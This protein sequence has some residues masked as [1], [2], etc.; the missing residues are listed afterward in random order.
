MSQMA[1]VP[2]LLDDDLL[3]VKPNYIYLLN[4]NLVRAELEKMWYRALVD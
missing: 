4:A 3:E 2:R 1:Q